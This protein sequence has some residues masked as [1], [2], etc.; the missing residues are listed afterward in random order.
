MKHTEKEK[1]CSMTKVAVIKII[2]RKRKIFFK[3]G[4]SHRYLIKVEKLV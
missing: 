2:T 3:I 1:S 4:E